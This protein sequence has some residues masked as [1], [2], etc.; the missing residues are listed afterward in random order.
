MGMGEIDD[1][2]LG[3]ALHHELMDELAC[4]AEEQLAMHH[5]LGRNRRRMNGHADG[6][7]FPGKG[8]SAEQDTK[9]HAY[10]QIIGSD[11]CNHGDK[12]HQRIT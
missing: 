3:V 4:C 7:D 9:Q 2:L 5:I 1:N 6:G 10:R 11:H 8:K 12:H